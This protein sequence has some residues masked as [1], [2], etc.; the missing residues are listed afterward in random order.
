MTQDQIRKAVAFFV[1]SSGKTVYLPPE[2]YNI[3]LQLINYDILKKSL[4][5]IG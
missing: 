5:L 2:Q 1:R 4:A 3:L